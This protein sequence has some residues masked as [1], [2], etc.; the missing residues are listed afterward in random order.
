VA[1]T[2]TI[3]DTTVENDGGSWTKVS[4]RSVKS[5]V[6]TDAKSITYSMVQDDP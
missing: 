5:A 6:G 2:P 3:T 4:T 1:G